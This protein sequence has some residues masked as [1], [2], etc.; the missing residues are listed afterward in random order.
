MLIIKWNSGEKDRDLVLVENAQ[1]MMYAGVEAIIDSYELDLDEAKAVEFEVTHEDKSVEY[2]DFVVKKENWLDYLG[3]SIDGLLED[4][5]YGK[6]VEVR[7]LMKKLQ[8][9]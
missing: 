6:I 8:D 1:A 5:E 9:E 7:A 3:K 4:E 2:L